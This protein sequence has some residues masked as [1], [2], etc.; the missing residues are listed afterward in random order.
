MSLRPQ[1]LLYLWPG[2][3]YVSDSREFV[4]RRITDRL[5]AFYHLQRR[6]LVRD[7][8]YSA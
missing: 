7:F 8:E 4:G 1:K 6:E 2:L 5:K 3:G